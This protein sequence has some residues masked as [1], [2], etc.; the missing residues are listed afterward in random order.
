M[1]TDSEQLLAAAEESRSRLDI[2]QAAELARRACEADPSSLYASQR[3][4]AISLEAG[5]REQTVR[6][7]FESLERFPADLPL[8]SDLVRGLFL[9]DRLEEANEHAK[10]LIEEGPHC[11]L[12]IAVY[13]LYLAFKGQA[14]EADKLLRN[15]IHEGFGDFYIYDN[16][17]ELYRS[18]GWDLKNILTP[19]EQYGPSSKEPVVAL[20]IRAL[21]H[22]GRDELEKAERLLDEAGGISP[23]SSIVLKGRIHMAR[24]KK[25]WKT[26]LELTDRYLAMVPG[27]EEFLFMKV[28]ALVRLRRA[29]EAIAILEP[30]VN[31]SPN[32]YSLRWMLGAAYLQ[33]L[34]IRDALREGLK[35][36]AKKKPS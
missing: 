34:R 28:D 31:L 25:D 7:C 10:V 26:A 15:E 8:R 5:F 2:G 13:A 30:A 6:I 16:L 35:L 11:S 14:Q 24:A 32:S 18:Q 3:A 4:A 12:A 20:V 19:L 33:R 21:V 36:A 29:K 1:M 9:L 17:Y 27:S 22:I 23:R